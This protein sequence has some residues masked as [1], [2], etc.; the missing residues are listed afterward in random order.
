MKI[1]INDQTYNIALLKEQNVKQALKLFL[2][3]HQD[4]STF[5]V[6]LNGDF[7]D[8]NDYQKISLSENDQLDVLFPIQGG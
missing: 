5:A 2:N 3:E 6:A 7:V 4:R 1:K 8:K